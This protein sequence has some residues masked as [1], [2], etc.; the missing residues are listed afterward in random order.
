M[1]FAQKPRFEVIEKA[2]IFIWHHGQCHFDEHLVNGGRV[3]GLAH[4]LETELILALDLQSIDSTFTTD[5]D[6]QV[7]LVDSRNL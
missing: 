1:V 5:T 7:G 6:D 2:V 4:N 3:V